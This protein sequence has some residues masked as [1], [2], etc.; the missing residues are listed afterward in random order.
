MSLLQCGGM[1][2]S[3]GELIDLTHQFFKVYPDYLFCRALAFNITTLVMTHEDALEI[4][5]KKAGAAQQNRQPITDKLDQRII[6][7]EGGPVRIKDLS[8]RESMSQKDE[9]LIE[10]ANF[11]LKHP[12]A[13]GRTKKIRYLPRY[14]RTF[15]LSVLVGHAKSRGLDLDYGAYFD[16][17]RL[18]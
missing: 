7:I 3:E 9:V 10:I 14:L 8:L 17:L 16:M 13:H 2:G 18:L 12:Y 5:T 6:M 4:L 15:F 1:G 11:Y